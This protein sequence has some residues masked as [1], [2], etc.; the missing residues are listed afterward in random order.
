MIKKITSFLL[1]FMPVLIILLG[2][3]S[4][5]FRIFFFL[6]ERDEMNFFQTSFSTTF[7][8][9]L[10]GQHWISDYPGLYLI[11]E[12]LLRSFTD[13]IH[14]IRFS[15]ILFWSISLFFIY[16]IINL[17]F[18]NKNISL[19][20]V[21]FFSVSHF[22]TELTRYANP[23]SLNLCFMII[24]IYF[25]IILYEKGKKVLLFSLFL[26][27]AI[28]THYI[29]FILLFC[30]ICFFIIR[31]L[32]DKKVNKKV[33]LGFILILFLVSPQIVILIKNSHGISRFLFSLDS[34]TKI[35]LM[36]FVNNC[37]YIFFG[38]ILRPFSFNFIFFVLILF[39]FCLVLK[40]N[41]IKNN[42]LY[43]ISLIFFFIPL[44]SIVIFNI[45]F[46]MFIPIRIFSISI[47][48]F[49][50]IV[51]TIISYFDQKNQK[52]I[53]LM[54]LICLFVII[55]SLIMIKKQYKDQPKMSNKTIANILRKDC[56]DNNIYIINSKD[57]AHYTLTN[58]Y[59]WSFDINKKDRNN[60][61][62][63]VCVFN[64]LVIFGKETGLI[65]QNSKNIDI[66][67][68]KKMYLIYLTREIHDQRLY[69]YIEVC[70]KIECIKLYRDIV[71]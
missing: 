58:Y 63:D 8:H 41:K 44:I 22:F 43:I 53:L 29:S 69:S 61:G 37:V 16:K 46:Q 51:L 11:F 49:Y 32:I 5:I 18:K 23:Y 66:N 60:F 25:F 55:G 20:G 48:G 14:L 62:N 27:L 30:F 1:V 56:S 68:K 45:L 24:S 15:N 40:T 21:S 2:T 3:A 34:N 54:Y 9:L 52:L 7:T 28:Y 38:E 70:K 13:N 50:F 6:A 17:L 33:L 71:K 47:I 67:K 12:K 65:I 59:L 64:N 4:K 26:S 31:S 57:Y 42:L 19:L 10:F 36:K 35:V 39:S